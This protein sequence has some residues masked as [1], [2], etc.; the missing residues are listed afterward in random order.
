[1]RYLLFPALLTSLYLTAPASANTFCYPTPF[2]YNC[3]GGGSSTQIRNNGLGG[4]DVETRSTPTYGYP[5][6]RTRT[7]CDAYPSGF[8]QPSYNCY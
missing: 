4:F 7:H 1:M 8:G 3:S 6:Q 5:T 2:G